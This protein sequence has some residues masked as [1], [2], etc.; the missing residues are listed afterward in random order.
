MSQAWR[1]IGIGFLGVVL[2]VGG[3]YLFNNYNFVEKSDKKIISKDDLSS[4]SDR[5]N[6][7]RFFDKTFDQD[8]FGESSSPFKQMEKIR[9]NMQRLFEDN[10]NDSFDN[11]YF[12]NWFEARF[13]SP[14]S[15]FG[16]SEDDEYIYYKIELEGIDKNNFKV[17]ITDG[18]LNISGGIDKLS[19]DSSGGSFSKS[20][21]R[22]SF[23]RIFPVPTGVDADKVEFETKENELIVKFP[24]TVS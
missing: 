5:N 4:T 7:D 2:G 21:V 19:E 23:N 24:K 18:Q 20:R 11:K 9:E 12:D 16:K 3:T 10:F 17:D 8:F 13:G 15:D 1:F 22:K 6:F 14:V